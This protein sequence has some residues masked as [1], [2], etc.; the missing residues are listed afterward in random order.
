MA[1]GVDD[2]QG[3]RVFCEK[4]GKCGVV[5]FGGKSLCMDTL[6]RGVEG[7]GVGDDFNGRVEADFEV[8]VFVNGRLGGGAEYD[9]CSVVGVEFLEAA[10][11]GGEEFDWQGLG[12]VEDDYRA[13]DAVKFAAAGCAVGVKGF[14]ELDVS[15]DD[16]ACVPIFGGKPIG[17]G[18]VLRIGV[19]VRMML[20][21]YVGTE[22]G[23][24][25]AENGGV[26][27][28]DGGER[29]DVD[30]AAEIVDACV[31]EGEGERGEG[32]SA[33]SGNGE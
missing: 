12:F 13:G 18:F 17:C 29:D 27:L 19:E 23:E 3:L 25:F 10:E 9:G 26:L 8:L 4:G 14:E 16:D 11:A 15:G 24:C 2:D 28:D 20:E 33:A 22:G 32:F 21:H 5:G 31:L 30:D 6:E 7:F 1:T